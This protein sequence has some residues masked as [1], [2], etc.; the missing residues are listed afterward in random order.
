MDDEG[1]G[2]LLALALG[3]IGGIAVLIVSR[4]LG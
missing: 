2:V 4:L 1:F 3:M